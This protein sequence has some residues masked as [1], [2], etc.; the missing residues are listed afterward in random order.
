MRRLLILAAGLVAA[1]VVA[2]LVL[3]SS[4]ARDEVR[5]A[6]ESRLSSTL[7][8]PVSIGSVG[9]SLF[10]GLVVTGTDVRIGEASTLAPAI[11]VDQVR[12]HPR[13]SSLWSGDVMIDDVELHGFVMA[14]L[15]GPDGWRLPAVVPAPS[16]GEPGGVAVDRVRLS[17][18]TLRVYEPAG[19]SLRERGRI[20][21]IDADILL[22]EGELRLPAI[23]GRIGG[24]PLEGHAAVGPRTARLHISSDAVADGD[25]PAFLGLL[26]AERP[27]FLRL[28][29]PGSLTADV[30]VDRGSLRLSGTGTLRAQDVALEPVRLAAFD[31][32]FVIEGSRLTFDP[33]TFALYG[34][35]H[36]GTVRFDSSRQ[37]AGWTTDSVVRGMDVAAFLD[38]LNGG[39]QRLD[40]TA[41]VSATLQGQVGASLIE[42]VRGRA[43]VE[44]ADGVIRE[45]PL[46]AY[47]N[48]ALRLAEGE[49]RDTRFERLTATLTIASGSATTDDLVLRASH[50]RVEAAG[51]IGADRSL[52]LRGTAAISPERSAEAIRSIRELSGLRNRQG[53]VEVPLT[54]SGTLDDPRFTLDVEAVLRKGIADEL[55]RRLLRIIR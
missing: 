40:G 12:I 4:L 5:E 42:S 36:E 37:P 17:D 16:A 19:E 28:S 35:A 20:D 49:G 25:L 10:A 18:A 7:G 50:L 1:L 30:E 3:R 39:D 46:L 29:E 15:R 14:V 21:A 33:A 24:S 44:V 31:A 11:S 34:G 2:V 13:V 22:D 41:T 53:E 45:F 48:T 23:T 6:V 26:G 52:S 38:A 8:Q 27:S 54:I 9:V 55:R 32:P 43:R 47:V 51:R